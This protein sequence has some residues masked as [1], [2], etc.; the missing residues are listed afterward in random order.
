LVYLYS[1]IKT[2]HGPINLRHTNN[3]TLPPPPHTHTH[4]HTHTHKFCH[5]YDQN[6]NFSELYNKILLHFNNINKEFTFVM[7]H[8]KQYPSSARIQFL[9]LSVSQNQTLYRRKK[10]LIKK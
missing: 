8:K 2:M 9:H 6:S 3:F 10:T 1:T 7:K 4:T 5:S